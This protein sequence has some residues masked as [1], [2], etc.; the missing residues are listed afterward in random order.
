MKSLA[1][2][3]T[4]TDT[5]LDEFTSAIRVAREQI[6][7]LQLGVAAAE[8]DA[9]LRGAVTAASKVR[10]NVLAAGASEADRLVDA[11]EPGT[12]IDVRNAD[13]S[14]L[15]DVHADLSVRVGE[16]R[17]LLSALVKPDDDKIQVGPPDDWDDGD[18]FAEV[19]R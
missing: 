3:P 12:V 6:I 18:V 11:S 4:K 1:D 13:A 8:T 9:A 5:W 14:V 15:F 19:F 17:R 7:E 2:P 16:L 10:D